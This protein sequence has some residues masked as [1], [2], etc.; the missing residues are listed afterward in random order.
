MAY[1]HEDCTPPGT[2]SGSEADNE[3]DPEEEEEQET[4][5]FKVAMLA[6]ATDPKQTRLQDFFGASAQSKPIQH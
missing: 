6:S 3:E 4:R 2:P 5:R 1:T